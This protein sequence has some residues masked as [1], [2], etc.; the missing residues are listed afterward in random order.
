MLS[1]LCCFLLCCYVCCF[2]AA[3]PDTHTHTQV[4]IKYLSLL[5]PLVFLPFYLLSIWAI[6][7][8]REWIRL[9]IIIHS[10]IL[11]VDLSAFFVEG[12]W[13][14]LPSPNMWIFTA[15]YGYYQLLSV[16]FCEHTRIRSLS[17][18]CFVTAQG[19]GCE[20]ANSCSPLLVVFLLQPDH[21][22]RALLER[23]PFHRRAGMQNHATR[24]G[25]LNQRGCTS[26]P[27]SRLLVRDVVRGI[28]L[29]GHGSHFLFQIFAFR[30]K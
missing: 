5:S 21:R 13:G 29:I 23:P 11:F 9:P 1:P 25:T 10:S 22:H 3:A 16:S 24:Q 14:D 2:L 19:G 20:R 30:L 18:R 27:A 4:W 26:L 28:I 7:T 15:G 12:I 17:I 8:R 6:L